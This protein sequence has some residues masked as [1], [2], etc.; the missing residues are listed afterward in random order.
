[1]QRV[2]RPVHPLSVVHANRVDRRSTRKI[3]HVVAITQDAN[4]VGAE[5]VLT[6]RIRDGIAEIRVIAAFDIPEILLQHACRVVHGEHTGRREI[7]VHRVVEILEIAIADD[8]IRPLRLNSHADFGAAGG[9][10]LQVPNHRILRGRRGLNHREKLARP[11]GQLQH[12]RG[13]VTIRADRHIAERH[14][15][16]VRQR[17]RLA[18]TE[19]Q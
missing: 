8:E 7:A 4:A 3:R 14:I 11:A 10:E 6:S 2:V 5:I 9:S 1:M 13:A 12:W 16:R 19:Q 17:K 18:T 15:D